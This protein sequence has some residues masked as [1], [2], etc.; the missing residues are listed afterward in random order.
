MEA[1]EGKR[2]GRPPKPTMQIAEALKEEADATALLAALEVSQKIQ[3]LGGTAKVSLA[4]RM[5]T[6][7]WGH[8]RFFQAS[9]FDMDK[10]AEE[11]GG[12]HYRALVYGQLPDGSKGYLPGMGGVFDIEGE[13]FPITRRAPAGAAPVAAP[14]VA[15][16]VPA[17]AEESMRMAVQMTQMVMGAVTAALASVRP[18]PER[19]PL[20]MLRAAKELF[21][22][23]QGDPAQVV[24][25][26]IGVLREGIEVGRNLEGPGDSYAGVL[27]EA[28]PMVRDVAQAITAAQGMS[29]AVPVPPV[30][31]RVAVGSGP[32]AS[33]EAL[34]EATRPAWLAALW[35]YLPLL[36][37]IA[38]GGMRAD[39]A[40]SMLLDKLP[41]S[42][43]EN[44]AEDAARPGFADRTLAA[45]PN[46]IVAPHGA[47]LS[48]VLREIVAEV[49]EEDDGEGE[50]G[51]VDQGRDAGVERAEG[52]L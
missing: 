6:G 44:V 7:D 16:P 9:T 24:R 50:G 28:L 38:R 36:S 40:A 1:K 43:W 10:I 49:S 8:V 21:S 31:V 17:A 33:P 45:L 46:A 5:E 18:A 20:D 52:D 25:D 14:V 19:D 22:G 30:P 12:G 29:H 41:D 37:G 39:L 32:A 15:A 42:L 35:P 34:A 26:H 4:R 48:D 3:S 11:F 2:R 27:R 47:W 13:S 23:G 51:E